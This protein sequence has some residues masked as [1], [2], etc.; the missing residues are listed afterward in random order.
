MYVKQI[1]ILSI[2]SFDFSFVNNTENELDL[3]NGLEADFAGFGQAII[4]SK[5]TKY[6]M[7]MSI[8]YVRLNNQYIYKIIYLNANL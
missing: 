2:F 6:G 8:G 7:L 3:G 1:N 5:A 4:P